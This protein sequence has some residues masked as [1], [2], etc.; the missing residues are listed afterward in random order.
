MAGEAPKRGGPG[1]PVDVA[2]LKAA[3][4]AKGWS[5][6]R[7]ADAAKCDPRVV[8]R[9]E[10]RGTASVAT[11]AQLAKVLGVEPQSL[12]PSASTPLLPPLAERRHQLPGVVAD[13]TGRDDEFR[14]MVARLRGAGGAVGLSA[15]RGMGGVGKTSLAVKVAHAVADHFPDAQLLLELHGT[16]DRPV[17]AAEAMARIIRDFHPEAGKLP[18]AEAELLPLYRSVLAGKR[19]L[20]VLDNARDEEQVKLLV[21]APPPAGFIITSRKTLRIKNVEVFPLDVLPPDKAFELLRGIVTAKGT[22]A[23]LWEVAELC[24]RLPLA[25]RVTGDFLRT[26]PTWTVSRYIGALRQERERLRR[27]K[28][29]TPE[30]DVEAVLGLSAAKLVRTNPEQAERWQ[31]LAVF[32]ADFAPDA[33]AAVWDF[34]TDGKP[35]L[36]TTQDELTDLLDRSLLQFSEETKRYSLHDLMR[37]VAQDAFE[38]ETAHPLLAGT[39][40]RLRT[41]ER[42]FAEHYCA[43]LAA[44]DD[45]YLKGDD[46]VLNGLAL[47]DREQANIQAGWAWASASRERDQLATALRRDYPNAGVYV[48][49]LRQPVRSQIVWLECSV[50]AC[51]SLEDRRGEGMALGNLGNAHADLGDARAAVGFHEQ[52]LA[53]ARES[54]DRLGEANANW[55][56]AST[57]VHLGQHQE[58]IPFAELSLAFFEAIEHPCIKEDRQTLA[59]WRAAAVPPGDPA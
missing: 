11:L 42:R 27:L 59:E 7:L 24:G 38:Y 9:I 31:M 22:E 35:D 36:D 43:V 47:F 2:A 53:V 54:G 25:V 30:D 10:A 56:T 34:Q 19:A 18:D 58:A 46:G 26:S 15:L 37:P 32:P 13:F 16:S 6:K 23:E 29:P 51:R 52:H 21:T 8:E 17:T 4:E 44:A 49:S 57:F 48:L 55:N 14:Q 3:R 28:G 40:D 12:R 33:A 5:Q 50:E 45:L 1:V 41:A 39:E 20:V